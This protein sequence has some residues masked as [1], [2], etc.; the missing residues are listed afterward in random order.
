MSAT[1]FRVEVQDSFYRR[2]LL[3]CALILFVV[4]IWL[5]R[6]N[7]IACQAVIQSL[8]T[9][10]LSLY[11]LPRIFSVNQNQIIQIDESGQLTWLLPHETFSWEISRQ[12]RFNGWWHWLVLENR[13]LKKQRNL[14]IFKDSLS[15][16]SWRHLCRIVRKKLSHERV[17]T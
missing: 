1:T 13:L 11:F 3:G 7:V 4:S 2:V 12:S 5:W 14:M 15:D 9:L 16:A 8:L 10:V 17:E 6:A